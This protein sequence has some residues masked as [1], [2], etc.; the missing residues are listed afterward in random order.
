MKISK[1]DDKAAKTIFIGYKHGWYKLYNP[2]TKKVIIS[3]D[4]TFA[5]DEEWQWNAIT[6]MDSKKTIYLH[7]ERW[8]GR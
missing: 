8:C 6:V 1:L 4:V 7:F 2:M 5:K 3:W